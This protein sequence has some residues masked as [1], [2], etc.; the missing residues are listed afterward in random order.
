MKQYTDS[1]VP[2]TKLV[3]EIAAIDTVEMA[4]VH[5]KYV[6]LRLMSQGVAGLKDDTL[7]A[8]FVDLTTLVGLTF[9][10][11]AMGKGQNAGYFA[12]G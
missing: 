6:T 9:L 12:A 1:T 2:K 7:R 3:N 8:H 11:E 5:M 4:Q 10:K